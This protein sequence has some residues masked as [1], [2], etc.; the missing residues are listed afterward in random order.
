MYDDIFVVEKTLVG[1]NVISFVCSGSIE[2][3]VSLYVIFRVDVPLFVSFI[4]GV[5]V[6]RTKPGLIDRI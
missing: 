3:V 6:V 1:M 2:N 4:S 5:W